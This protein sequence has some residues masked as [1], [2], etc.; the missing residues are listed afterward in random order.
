MWNGSTFIFMSSF[1]DN[2]SVCFTS[3]EDTQFVGRYIYLFLLF[4]KYIYEFWRGNKLFLSLFLCIF[5]FF[6]FCIF[7]IPSNVVAAYSIQFHNILWRYSTQKKRGRKFIN[8]HV[9]CHICI[10]HVL[11]TFV[12]FSTSSYSDFYMKIHFLIIWLVSTN[13]LI[14]LNDKIH[15]INYYQQ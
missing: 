6:F 4:H 5:I 12:D 3:E 15:I 7:L 11:Y 9:C 2:M 8:K 1:N 13:K 10:S 14:V